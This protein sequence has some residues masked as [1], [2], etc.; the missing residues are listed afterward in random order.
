MLHWWEYGQ[1]DDDD[2]DEEEGVIIVAVRG[3][4]SGLWLTLVC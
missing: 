4:R 1:P 3:Y 2:D